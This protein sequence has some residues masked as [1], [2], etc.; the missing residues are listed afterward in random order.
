MPYWEDRLGRVEEGFIRESW[1]IEGEDKL[2]KRGWGEE[3]AWERVGEIEGA[4]WEVEGEGAEEVNI[5]QKDWGEEETVV[6]WD[7]EEIGLR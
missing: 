7:L 2:E 3:E 1:Y 6:D 4:R 5:K